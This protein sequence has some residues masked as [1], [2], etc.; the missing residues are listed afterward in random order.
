MLSTAAQ[1]NGLIIE[2]DACNEVLDA[3]DVKLELAGEAEFGLS[4]EDM[5][6]YSRLLKIGDDLEPAVHLKLLRDLSSVLNLLMDRRAPHF[7]EEE[8]K[9]HHKIVDEFAGDLDGVITNQKRPY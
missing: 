5:A 6:L 1:N 3:A 9:E 4:I 2:I 8:R 7:S